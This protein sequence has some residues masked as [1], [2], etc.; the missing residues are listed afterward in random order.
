M[1][2]Q[3]RQISQRVRGLRE[4]ALGAGDSIFFDSSHGHGMKSVGKEPAKFLAVIL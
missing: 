2:Q 3:I 1:N 4:I